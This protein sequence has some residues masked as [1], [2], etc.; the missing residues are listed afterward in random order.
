[1]CA[2]LQLCL[3]LGLEY[4]IEVSDIP[5]LVRGAGRPKHLVRHIMQRFPDRYESEESMERCGDAVRNAIDNDLAF[6]WMQLVD[7]G[8][9]LRG[10]VPGLACQPVQL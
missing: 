8:V 10:E 2:R 9:K 7:R 1:M 5:A 6:F 4:A 3:P